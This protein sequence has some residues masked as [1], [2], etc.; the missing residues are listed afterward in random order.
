[1]STELRLHLDEQPAACGRYISYLYRKS[2]SY[3]STGF[4]EIGLSAMQSILLVGI[5]RHEELNQ[6]TLAEIIAVDPGVASRTLRE[7]EDRGYI[8]KRRDEQNRRSYNLYLTPRGEEEAEKSLQIQGEYWNR[9][10][11][12]FSGEEITVLNDLLR[13]MECRACELSL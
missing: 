10:L 13:R 7:L 6:R 2:A 8:E 4:K 1:M 3:C 9:L 12:E 11:Q 5:Y